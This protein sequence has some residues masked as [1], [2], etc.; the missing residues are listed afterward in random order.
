MK[1]IGRQYEL[2]EFEKIKSSSKSEFVA[3]YGRRRVGKTF[4][5]RHAFHND[6]T[7]HFTGLAN[8][9]LDD[10]LKNFYTQLSKK[11][12]FKKGIV[13]AANWLEAFEH[14][15]DYLSKQRTK[16]KTIFIDELPWLATSQSKFI[17]ALEYF[18][19]HWASARKDIVLVVCG[20]AASWMIQHLLKNKGG[21]H[22]RVT[23]RMKVNPFTLTECES[24]LKHKHFSI[25]RY[26][27]TQLYMSLGGVPFYLDM[28][29]KSKSVAQNINHLCFSKEGP[30]R[31]EFDELYASLFKS[32]EKYKAVIEALS[33]KAK[34]LTRTELL[35]LSKLSSAGSTTRILEELE[36]SG[37]ISKYMSYE[38]NERDALYQ[39]TDFYSNFYFKHIKKASVL[40]KNYWF[41]AMDSNAYK[42]WCGYAFEQVCLYHIDEIKNAL[43][44]S[45]VS[46]NSASWQNK[47]AQ[48]DLLIDRNDYIINICEMKFS[49]NEFTI[50]KNYFSNLN[51]KIDEFKLASKTKKAVHLTMITANGVKKNQYSNIIMQQNINLDSLF[52]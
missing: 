18:W 42:T 39:L 45:G 8:A 14:L 16:K 20:S 40:D 33:K 4:L 7:F 12:T 47:N 37:F 48:I 36:E 32:P 49:I 21:L 24:F 50:D 51:R 15:I 46:T 31:K 22:N 26:E 10:Q 27:I 34:G 11:H 5:I 9:K 2:S 29:D 1:I 19:N 17:I 35:K 44:I 43:G 28:L 23:N 13:P 3:V 52:Q 25:S 41:N 6:F 38:K 30:L